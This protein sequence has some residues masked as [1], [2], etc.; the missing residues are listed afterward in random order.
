LIF[1]DGGREGGE[2]EE[3]GRLHFNF[4]FLWF[5][6]QQSM[7]SSSRI[8]T[9]LL[10]ERGNMRKMT[11]CDIYSDAGEISWLPW[12]ELG[13][14]PGPLTV[15]SPAI[16]LFEPGWLRI[17]LGTMAVVWR[18]GLGHSWWEYMCYGAG[19]KHG[20]L[21]TWYCPLYTVVWH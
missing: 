18:R 8:W 11:L 16:A 3:N 10:Q 4:H 17:Y 14:V 13:P 19:W 12:Q 9:L 7:Q 21:Q 20:E 6:Q 2:E 5:D 15:P 1:Y